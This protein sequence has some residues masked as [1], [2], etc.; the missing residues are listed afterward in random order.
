MTVITTTGYQPKRI[1]NLNPPLLTHSKDISIVIPVK[2]NQEGV[3]RFLSELENTQTQMTLPKEVIIVDNNSLPPIVITKTY[4]FD[5]LLVRCKQGG[6]A[7]A[8]NMGVKRAKTKWILFVDSDCLPTSSLLVGYINVLPKSVAYAGKV[9]AHGIDVLSNY[10]DTQE[11]LIPPK[12]AQDNK[13][14]I[15]DYLI[16]AN[17]LVWKQAF[18]RVGGFDERITIA[19]GEDID[20]GFRLLQVGDINYAFES[21]VHHDFDGGLLGFRERFIRYGRGNRIVE[22]LFSLD[23]KPRPFK[24]NSKKVV[25][26]ILAFLQYRWLLQGW[27]IEGGSIG[28]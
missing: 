5:L 11:I 10:Y 17:C 25:N 21:V 28:Q 20:L 6:P 1:D 13:T 2:D 27:R 4:S 9:K 19:G 12:N 26:Y 23:L 7:C 8:R 22:H 15:P 14:P 3:D 24:P 18:N 16:T